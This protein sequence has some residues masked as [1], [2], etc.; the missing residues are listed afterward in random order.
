MELTWSKEEGVTILG[1]KGRLDGVTAP[2]AEGQVKS[3]LTGQDSLLVGDLTALEYISS[4]G[5]RLMLLAAKSLKAKGGKL[6]LFGAR[7]TVKEAFDISGFSTIIPLTAAK[8]A[9]VAAAKG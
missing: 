9:A 6:A 5:L 4:A 3:W 8:A 2:T 1:F 7:P